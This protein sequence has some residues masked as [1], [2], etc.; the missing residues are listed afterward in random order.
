MQI[1]PIFPRLYQISVRSRCETIYA[2]IK[3]T[4]TVCNCSHAMPVCDVVFEF[5]VF[6]SWTLPWL[7]FT[8]FITVKLFGQIA[9]TQRRDAVEFRYGFKLL[10]LAF[11]FQTRTVSVTVSQF[12]MPVLCERNPYKRK[13]FVQF[14]KSAGIVWT[15]S[16]SLVLPVTV[17]IQSQIKEWK[18]LLGAVVKGDRVLLLEVAV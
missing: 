1:F 5:V 2:G 6:L 18:I 13:N 17:L 15:G 8:I 9:F 3:W 7:L 11:L 16:S 12:F 10:R 14:S 4:R